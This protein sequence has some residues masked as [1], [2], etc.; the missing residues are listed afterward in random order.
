MR[1]NLIEILAEDY[2]PQDVVQLINGIDEDEL[3]AYALKNDICSQCGGN[4]VVH[5]WKE[6]HEYWGSIVFEDMEELRC[7]DC[8]ETY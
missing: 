7:K 8:R 4:L 1:K 2:S 3:T 5:R 6:K